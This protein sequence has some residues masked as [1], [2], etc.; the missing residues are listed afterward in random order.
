MADERGLGAVRPFR[1]AC[2][3][4]GHCCSGGGGQVW[5]D[6]D[7]LP[8]LAAALSMTVERLAALHLR[9]AFDERAG[10]ERLSIKEKDAAGGACVL[11]AGA[12]TCLAYEARPRHC[13]EFPFWEHVLA[14]GPAYE[15]ARSTC[16]GIAEVVEPGRLAAAA[17]ELS[18]LLDGLAP[19][20]AP[21]EHC[22]LD[23]AGPGSREGAWCGGLEADHALAS[24][25][26]AD[27]CRFGAARPVAC[28]LGEASAEAHEAA[29]AAVRAIERRHSYPASYGPVAAQLRSRGW[30]SS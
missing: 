9:R 28:R 5:I 7:E 22:C 12:N 23:A 2:Q 15:S 29:R 21:R 27:G 4:C 16:P 30:E 13:R 14:G 26:P 24:G 11:L 10:R 19:R 17:A 1:F 20:A 25:H 6:E 8:A 3:R 18:S